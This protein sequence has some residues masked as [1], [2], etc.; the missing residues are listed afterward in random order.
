MPTATSR[1]RPSLLA[2]SWT[3]KLKFT[4]RL[5]S[6]V[7][8]SWACTEAKSSVDLSCK[9]AIHDTLDKDKIATQ[10][11]FLC[12]LDIREMTVSWLEEDLDGSK[13]CKTL[14]LLFLDWCAGVEVADGDNVCR[15]ECYD[16]GSVACGVFFCS[17]HS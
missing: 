17:A 10:I 14:M 9:I 7:T 12:A 4:S 2:L 1:T 6:V 5:A 11:A 16:G 15:D 13:V 3:W 8:S